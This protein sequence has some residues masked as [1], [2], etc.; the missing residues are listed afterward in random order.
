MFRISLIKSI[1]RSEN[2]IDFSRNKNPLTQIEKFPK[3]KPPPQSY[4]SHLWLVQKPDF[5]YPAKKKKV[6]SLDVSHHDSR[7]P[8]NARPVIVDV[9]IR[10]HRTQI[11]LINQSNR[12]TIRRFS[13]TTPLNQLTKAN[14]KRTIIAYGS[15][16]F[17]GWCRHGILNTAWNGR[18]IIVDQT[19]A[20]QRPAVR[21]GK[22]LLP[23]CCQT[24]A[25]VHSSYVHTH[26][27]HTGKYLRT[28]LR[29]WIRP[30]VFFRI[31]RV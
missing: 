10:W 4:W 21:G 12:E 28:G 1:T 31:I 18:N 16:T 25:T 15:D 23:A 27:S 30:D 14:D 22:H 6:H 19:T 29:L 20:L 26:S 5:A 13:I 17:N 9:Y 11:F 2:F 24:L 8:F 7:A 3:L